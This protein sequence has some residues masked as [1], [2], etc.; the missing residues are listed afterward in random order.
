MRKELEVC[1]IECYPQKEFDEDM[2]KS[3]NDKIRVR[4]HMLFFFF[5]YFSSLLS[6]LDALI[7]WSICFHIMFVPLNLCITGDDALCR[8]RK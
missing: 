3:D 2:D 1:G 6:S 7:C 5:T 8:G 4:S